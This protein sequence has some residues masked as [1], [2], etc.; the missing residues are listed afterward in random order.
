MKAFSITYD[1][2]APGRDYSGLYEEIKRSSNWWHYLEST[3][4]IVTAEDPNGIWNRLNPHI[5]DDDNLLIIEV[6]HNVQGWLPQEAWDW[7][8][9]NV[10][11][12]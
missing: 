5:D 3:W 12:P 6:R 7:I 10:P 2:S 11:N 9:S 1:L 8:H 4:I